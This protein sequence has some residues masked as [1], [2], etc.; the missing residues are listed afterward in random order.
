VNYVGVPLDGKM[1]TTYALNYIPT[2]RGNI[3]LASSDPSDKPLIDHNHYATKADRHQ[4]HTRARMITRL[5]NTPE[6]KEMISGEAVPEGHEAF[7]ED[8]A[9][10]DIDVRVGGGS[11]VFMRDSCC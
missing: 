10:G 6:V 8:S 4:I 11:S 5:M 2:S 1:V 3:A 7:T 9:D